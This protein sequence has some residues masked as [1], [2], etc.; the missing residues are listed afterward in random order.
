MYVR[1]HCYVTVINCLNQTFDVSQGGESD[2]LTTTTTTSTPNTSNKEN[3][4]LALSSGGGGGG[5]TGSHKRPS[6]PDS[7]GGL[8]APKDAVAVGGL[9]ALKPKFSKKR[10][11]LSASTLFPSTD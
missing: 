10:K 11:L 2:S 5:G 6:E 9:A 3:S 7:S 1:K 8:F 4:G